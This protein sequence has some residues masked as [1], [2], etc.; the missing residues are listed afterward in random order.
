MRRLGWSQAAGTLSLID[1]QAR[2]RLAAGY[3]GRPRWRND[4]TAQHRKGEGPLPR[5]LYRMKVVPHPRFAGPAVRLDP[6]AGN[7]MLG[8]SDFWIHGDNA[9]GDASS[10]C[11]VLGR[12]ARLLVAAFID[13]GCSVLEVTE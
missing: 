9:E 1:G 4:A 3:A 8:R 12:P 7:A 10:G 2:A 13:C 5:G 6:D 11:I